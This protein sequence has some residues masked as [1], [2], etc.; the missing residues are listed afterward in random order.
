M[1]LN[2]LLFE[3]FKNETDEDNSKYF[4]WIEKKRQESPQ[5]QYWITTMELEAILLHF[6]KTLRTADFEEF[7]SV[8]ERMCP[9]YLVTDH[10]HY[11]RWLPVFLADM[12]KLREKHPEIYRQFKMGHF[13]SRRTNKKF[14][15]IP[16]DQF[17][18]QNNKMVKESS[19]FLGKFCTAHRWTYIYSQSKLYFNY[20]TINRMFR[21]AE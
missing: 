20:L 10:G 3:T 9:W 19:S 15:C 11:G 2:L 17:H 6:V 7:I 12:K 21:Y 16:D 13:T 18:E 8:M 4:K 14:S 5:F 1:A